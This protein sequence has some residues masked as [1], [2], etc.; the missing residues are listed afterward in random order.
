MEGRLPWGPKLF[1]EFS[2]LESFGQ[3]DCALSDDKSHGQLRAY[4]QCD[5]LDLDDSN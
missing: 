3:R 2:V 1:P 5:A 4:Y